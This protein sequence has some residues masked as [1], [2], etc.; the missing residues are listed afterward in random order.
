MARR[1]GKA[2]DRNRLGTRVVEDGG[3]RYFEI[4]PVHRFF[5]IAVGSLIALQSAGG[6]SNNITADLV[7]GQ[8]DFNSNNAT[9]SQT[10][11]NDPFEVA[12]DR[13]VSPNRIY[14]AD[15]VNNRVLG[16]DS[17]AALTNGAPAELLIGSTG[18]SVGGDCCGE[19]SNLLIPS[20]LAVDSQGNLYVAEETNSPSI[21]I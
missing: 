1:A 3:T 21:G 16:W 20:G 2:L 13:S 10:G 8:P 11:L 14:V 12:I 7:L 4:P 9:L 17:V 19:D 6:D 15:S 5:L 18:F